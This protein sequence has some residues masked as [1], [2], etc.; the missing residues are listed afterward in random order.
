MKNA[1][2]TVFYRTAHTCNS[3]LMTMALPE[4]TEK[5]LDLIRKVFWKRRP[6]AVRID[7]IDIVW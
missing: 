4:E 7:Q 1:H 5:A 6:R 2:V 3:W